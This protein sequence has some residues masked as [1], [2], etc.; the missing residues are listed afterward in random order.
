MSKEIDTVQN[1]NVANKMTRKMEKPAA[2]LDGKKKK[3]L[4]GHR[5]PVASIDHL[6]KTL[7]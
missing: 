7:L 4:P 1:F 2:S 6:F 5:N 3:A